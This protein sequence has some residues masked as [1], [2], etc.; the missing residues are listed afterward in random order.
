MNGSI[1]KGISCKTD[2][3]NVVV[4]NIAKI[5]LSKYL[6]QPKPSLLG[7]DTS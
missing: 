2:C 6:G 5:A 7:I 4:A 1:N 3:N